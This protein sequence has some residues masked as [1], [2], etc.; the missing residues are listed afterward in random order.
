[1]M[2][3]PM[4]AGVLII[5]AMTEANVAANDNTANAVMR[6]QYWRNNGIITYCV[7]MA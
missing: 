1:M 4:P 7:T 6:N 5:V 3:K 2:T